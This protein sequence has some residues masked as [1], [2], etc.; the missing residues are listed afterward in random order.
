MY[1]SRANDGAFDASKIASGVYMRF[2]GLLLDADDD[3]VVLGE[4][5][6]DSGREL[7]ALA[8]QHGTEAGDALARVGGGRKVE[9]EVE[10]MN[11]LCLFLDFYGSLPGART[12]CLVVVPRSA[13]SSSYIR[14]GLG[15]LTGGQ[16]QDKQDE[17]SEIDFEII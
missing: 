15:F 3:E 2:P 5:A 8:G 4:V 14:I 10:D 6:L 17:D 16:E 1:A 11:V 13:G 12:L 9:D 7:W